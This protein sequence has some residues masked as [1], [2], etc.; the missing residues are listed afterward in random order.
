MG[1]IEIAD[2][3]EIGAFERSESRGL[4]EWV[5]GSSAPPIVSHDFKTV[6]VG[7]PKMPNFTRMRRG[8][9]LSECVV[10][11]YPIEAVYRRALML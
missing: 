2:R 9:C 8:S 4:L 7:R 3:R 5:E 1:K 11:V 10:E 6:A